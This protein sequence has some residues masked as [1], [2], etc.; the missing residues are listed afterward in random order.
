M[1]TILIPTVIQGI[2]MAFFFIPLVTVALSGIPPE[3]IPAA[4][5]LS[6]FV[7]IMAGAM[8][9]SI[10][11]TLWDNRAALHHAQLAEQ[12]GNA[13]SVAATDFFGKLAAA[14][15]SPQQASAQ[16]NR[17]IDQQ[18]Y[19]LAAS[20]VFSASAALFIVLIGLVWLARPVKAGAAAD[21]SGAH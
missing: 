2:S 8:G 11:T 7:R 20:D 21:A 14:G 18:A 15:L 19:M 9:T 5:G 17:L 10:A 3:R 12:I 1:T 16:V 13:S 4:S 6:N